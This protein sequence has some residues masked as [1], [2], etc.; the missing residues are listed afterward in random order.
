MYDSRTR[1]ADQVADEVRSHFGDV[2]LATSIPRSVRVSE[3]PGYGQSVVTYDP[4]SRGAMAY[5]DAAREIARRGAE[6]GQGA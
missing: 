2:V 4:G 6:E 3:A 1:L 5:V